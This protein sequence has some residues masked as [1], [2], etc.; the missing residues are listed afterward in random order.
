MKTLFLILF[1]STATFAQDA[2]CCFWS[3]KGRVT[4]DYGRSVRTTVQM[5]GC[6]EPSCTTW[7]VWNTYSN[8]FGYFQFTDIPAQDYSLVVVSKYGSYA[9]IASPYQHKFLDVVVSK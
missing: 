1:L 5:W 9:G 3:V 4:D 2:F 8:T 7:R 6:G